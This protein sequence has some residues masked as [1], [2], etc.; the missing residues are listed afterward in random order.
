MD[1]ELPEELREIQRTVRDFCEAKVKPHA[2]RGT[3]RAQF[4]WEVVRE[5]GPLGL[6]GIARAGGVGGA[7]WARS[8]WRW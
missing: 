3:R 7:G 4:P 8:A 6:M 5:L 1:F 2:R